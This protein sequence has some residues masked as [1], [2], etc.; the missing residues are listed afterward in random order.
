[1]DPDPV[2]ELAKLRK[3]RNR[4]PA[5]LSIAGVVEQLRKDLEKQVKR[6][7]GIG[8]VWETVAPA[9]LAAVA[10]VDRLTPSGTLSLTV[11]DAGARYQLD[12]WLRS[13]GLAALQRASSAPIRRVKVGERRAAAKKTGAK[14]AG[15]KRTG[16]GGGSA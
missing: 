2:R 10:R 11:A 16:R 13:G 3:F 14:V 6:A 7:E 9:D 1:M 12:V 4:A 8:R 5:D 15:A